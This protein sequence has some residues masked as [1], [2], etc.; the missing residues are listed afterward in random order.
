VPVI[1]RL[2]PVADTV[3]K[4][5]LAAIVHVTATTQEEQVVEAQEGIAAVI[6]LPLEK[7]AVAMDMIQV[8]LH[9]VI[10]VVMVVA[11]EEAGIVP[12]LQGMVAVV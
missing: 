3:V 5:V 8:Q 10:V 7:E 2:V 12:I 1:T 9:L 6:H 11:E 4:A